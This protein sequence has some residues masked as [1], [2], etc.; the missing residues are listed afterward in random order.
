MPESEDNF[1]LKTYFCFEDDDHPTLMYKMDEV[2]LS[3]LISGSSVKLVVISACYS[4]QL[5]KVFIEAGIPVVISINASDQVYEKAAEKF[6]K[7][8]LDNL[9]RGQ[10]PLKAFK[11]GTDVLNS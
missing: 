11:N 5:G 9:I 8:F 4:S 1:N 7:I 2:S 10:T 3:K 6:N